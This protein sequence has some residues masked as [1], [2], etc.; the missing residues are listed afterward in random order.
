VLLWKLFGEN[1]QRLDVS[2]TNTSITTLQDHAANWF[3]ESIASTPH[4]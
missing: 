4:L 3:L 2:L 1:D